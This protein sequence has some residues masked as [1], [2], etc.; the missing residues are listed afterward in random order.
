D[1]RSQPGDEGDCTDHD[2]LRCQ[3]PPRP[4]W[5]SR[6]GPVHVPLVV[7]GDEP[8]R[9][10]YHHDRPNERTNQRALDRLASYGPPGSDV[11]GPGHGERPAGL[12]DP[13]GTME[14]LPIGHHAVPSYIV[15]APRAGGIALQTDM[16]KDGG[17]LC[18]ARCSFT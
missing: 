18:E 1:G 11:A 2:R 3:H 17:S 15:A 10:D 5:A 7:G 6:G 9:N 8:H 13:G 4:G 14:T 12:L 16:V